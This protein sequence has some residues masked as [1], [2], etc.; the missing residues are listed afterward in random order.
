VIIHDPTI[1]ERY[2]QAFFRAAA[3]QGITSKILSEAEALISV[4]EPYSKARIFFESPQITTEDKQR[5]ID[6]T[7]QD[8]T[9]KLIHDLLSLLLRKG[10]IEY[11]RPILDRFRIIVERDQGIYE[12][13]IATAKPLAE[14][15]KQT[16]HKAL[17][18][19]TRAKLKL[20]YTIKPELIA[21]V[22]FSYGDTLV[23]DTVR[24]KLYR[25]R[26]QLEAAARA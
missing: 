20:N 4:F 7:F 18:N 8:R 10:R 23:D 12:A 15:E 24:G 19:F 22:R 16:L 9:D 26:Q 5:L 2:A 6:T 1:A 3:K 21:G 14:A 13:E 11:V 25:L 17:E